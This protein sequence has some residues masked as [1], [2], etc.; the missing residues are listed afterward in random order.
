[1]SKYLIKDFL[2]FVALR[3]LHT[4]V[5][6]V[7]TVTTSLQVQTSRQISVLVLLTCWFHAYKC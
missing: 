4:Q 5:T 3:R 1:M 6:Q 7:E 2:L